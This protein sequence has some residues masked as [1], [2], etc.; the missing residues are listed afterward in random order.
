[1]SRRGGGSSSVIHSSE[2]T[3]S[4]SAS[5]RRQI[6]FVVFFHS[7]ATGRQ[8]IW[9]EL[10]CVR[11][12][13]ICVHLLRDLCDLWVSLD[14]LLLSSSLRSTQPFFCFI[15]ARPP[16]S[17]P[18]HAVIQIGGF[19]GGG[20]GEHREGHMHMNTTLFFDFVILAQPA[21]AVSISEGKI[22]K[23]NK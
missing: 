22:G 4:S 23:G 5:C 17:H 10:L 13:Q 1:M 19:A 3:R 21:A 11:Q 2:T 6:T 14:H 16:N 20:V 12:L 15:L 7:R 18:F 9:L 8:L